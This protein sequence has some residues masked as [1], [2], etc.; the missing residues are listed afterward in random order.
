MAIAV[1]SFPSR[2]PRPESLT[3]AP[4]QSRS[5]AA[6]SALVAAPPPFP[7][8]PPKPTLRSLSEAPAQRERD[9]ERI[10]QELKAESRALSLVPLPTE[11]RLRH[12]SPPGARR[13]R[14]M[15]V[16][17]RGWSAGI[18]ERRLECDSPMSQE[19]Q[20]AAPLVH[21]VP[22]FVRPDEYL[23][24][25]ST[26]CSSRAQASIS[27]RPPRKCNLSPIDQAIQRELIG[28]GLAL[29]QA[30]ESRREAGWAVKRRHLQKS[31]LGHCCHGC[32]QPL[33]N[34]GEEV[35]IW[36]GA[37]I[38]RRFHPA[39][40][41]SFVLKADRAEAAA[42]AS[43]RD[44]VEGYADGWRAL[45]DDVGDTAASAARAARA[46]R[47]WLLS[48]D[49]EAWQPLRGD[50]FTTITVVENGQKKSVPGL[51]QEHFRLLNSQYQY[52]G[53]LQEADDEEEAALECA[54]CFG[55]VSADRL[56]W[57]LPCAPQHVFHVDC[58]QPW[59]RKASLCPTCRTD[60]RPLL[61][62]TR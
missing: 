32:R 10:C 3:V 21:N 34:L 12:T 20:G 35:T 54:I 2:P 23:R 15:H 31:D 14:P 39:C 11:L 8:R 26:L 36:T 48:Q 4:A 55:A 58:V 61:R 33:R 40:A 37:A 9:D 5:L 25:I 44:L 19:S 47:Q 46:A 18:A 41:A 60:L 50:L 22:S 29:E 13:Q 16:P 17:T 59:L 53:P 42:A 24:S 28:D 52:K 38:Y 57:N 43:G 51:M 27:S 30:V 62:A 1:P 7:R 6:A 49:Q 56:C 45:P